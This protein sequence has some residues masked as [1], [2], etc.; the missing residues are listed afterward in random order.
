MSLPIVRLCLALWVLLVWSVGLLP[1]VLDWVLW[2]QWVRWLLC[3][4]V[5]VLAASEGLG[6][7]A[8]PSVRLGDRCSLLWVTGSL[9]WVARLGIPR[10]RAPRRCRRQVAWAVGNLPLRAVGPQRVAGPIV[11]LVVEVAVLVLWSRVGSVVSA[12]GAVVFVLLV[13]GVLVA[14]Q[15]AVLLR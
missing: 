13:L 4:L 8:R 14:S 3:L 11:P 2:W 12:C 6:R 10:R 7:V 9:G 5:L 15:T 1:S